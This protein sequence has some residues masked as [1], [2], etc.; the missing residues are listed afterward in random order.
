MK[1]L[2]LIPIVFILSACSGGSFW[3]NYSPSVKPRIDAM[4]EAKDCK[5][6]QENFEV[7]WN[8][9]QAQMDRVGSNNAKLLGYIDEAMKEI[10]CYQ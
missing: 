2:I 10:G 6:L 4:I 9:N 1:K 7:A 8:N 5:G 3:D